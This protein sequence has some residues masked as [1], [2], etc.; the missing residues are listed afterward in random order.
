VIEVSAPPVIGW[1]NP[2]N[3]KDRACHPEI[4]PDACADRHRCVSSW[5]RT[6]T[7][8]WDRLQAPRDHESSP[9]TAIVNVALDAIAE[10][11]F[12]LA[13]AAVHAEL[14]A[15]TA[16]HGADVRMIWRS[17]TTAMSEPACAAR[18]WL[19]RS[20]QRAR[21]CRCGDAGL[22]VWIRIA[23]LEL[24]GRSIAMLSVSHDAPKA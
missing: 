10:H 23:T 21:N 5:W 24:K 16:Q 14:P 3:R 4:S 22:R 13:H 19:S 17:P 6:I 11:G 18:P 12:H 7:T 8:R 2:D 15:V 9:N 20:A 1:S